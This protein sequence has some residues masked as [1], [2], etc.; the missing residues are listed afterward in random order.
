MTVSRGVTGAATVLML[1]LALLGYGGAG[2]AQPAIAPYERAMAPARPVRA[3]APILDRT[4][5]A[6][7][8]LVSRRVGQPPVVDGQEDCMWSCAVPLPIPLTL[9]RH[10]QHHAVDVKLRSLYTDQAIYFLAEWVGEPPGAE[11]AVV[12]N[13]LTL[14]FDTPEPEPGA[15][16]RMCLVACHTAFADDAG[17]LVYLS[18]ETIPP[19]R[20]D[21]LPAA[22]GW[23]AGVW[24]LEWSRQLVVDNRFDLQF[25]DLERSYRFFVKVF[26]WEEGQPDPVSPDCLLVFER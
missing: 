18:A 5:L 25:Q 16:D 19:G 2:V 23:N 26:Q 10:G 15:A 6:V 12:R 22:G 17:R 20:T 4:G 14:H 1:L 9:G 21:P 11:Q 24:R 3:S 7:P 13:R 8:T